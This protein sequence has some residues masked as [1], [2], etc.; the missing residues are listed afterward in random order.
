MNFVTIKLFVSLIIFFI[1]VYFYFKL[2]KSILKK[3]NFKRLYIFCA[4]IILIAI[5]FI[6]AYPVENLWKSFNNVEE[7]FK[8]KFPNY[9]IVEKLE[10]TN[11]AVVLYSDK[12]SLLFE[13]F[14]KK[15]NNWKLTYSLFN[16]DKL[17]TN[18]LDVSCSY[19]Y[20]EIYDKILIDISCPKDE[21]NIILKSDG[22]E[23]KKI[24]LNMTE[25]YAIVDRNDYITYNGKMIEFSSD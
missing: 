22:S 25:Y 13:Y 7:A 3:D 19:S 10:S 18:F 24:N 14:A 16:H 23:L 20:T 8:Y 6:L 2:S 5:T 9:E 21:N 4:F 15:D 11:I 17:K 12:E 1:V